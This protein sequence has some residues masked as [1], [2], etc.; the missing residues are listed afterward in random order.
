MRVG[1]F[2][3]AGCI[4]TLIAN[5]EHYQRIKL[6]GMMTRPFTLPT[7]S[8]VVGRDDEDEDICVV[9]QSTEDDA[10][11]E[12]QAIIDNNEKNG[13]LEV[14]NEVNNGVRDDHD[15][16]NGEEIYDNLEV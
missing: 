4:L 16:D 2:E 5:N 9:V 11:A 3:S 10:L 1:C 8:I 15:S 12:E 7:Q 6:H 13:D 14:E